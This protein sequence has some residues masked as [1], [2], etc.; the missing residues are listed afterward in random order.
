MRSRTRKLIVL[1][2]VVVIVAAVAVA[3]FLRRRGAPEPARL[4]PDGEAVIFVNLK[5]FRLL[6]GFGDKQAAARE[7]EYEQFV[8]ETGFQFERDLD[9]AA[10]VQHRR[11][12]TG[13][14]R[15]GSARYSEIFIGRFD[16][17]RVSNYLRKLSRSTERYRDTEIFSIP[18]EDRTVRVAI[19]GV[20]TV[21]GSN[22]EDGSVIHGM[23]DRYKHVALPFAGPEL[24]SDHYKDVPL[25]SPVWGISKFEGDVKAEL[26][27]GFSVFVPTPSVLVV[28]ARFTGN[29]HARAELFAKDEQDA[30]KFADQASTFLGIFRALEGNMQTSG[31]DP[32]VKAVFDSLKVDREKERAIITASIPIA[33][34]KKLL[35]EPPAELTMQPAPSPK[36]DQH[37]P[38]KVPAERKP[39]H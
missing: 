9:Q 14:I 17:Q 3:I 2:V 16:A 5:T 26:P 30:N 20:D 4:L 37:T 15:S 6:T 23:I 10:F 22:V 8:R 21:A 11:T 12:S 38:E 27:G 36:T 24:L 35:S 39:Q 18:V 13:A 28:S 19:L 31:S 33:F 1:G 32:D 7:P 29:I 34:F 25:A